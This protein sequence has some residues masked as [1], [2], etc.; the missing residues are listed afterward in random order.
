MKVKEENVP[1]LR[2]PEFSGEWEKKTLGEFFSF[3][4]GVNADKSKYGS[5]Y[6]FVN[7]LDIIADHP[8]TSDSIIGKVSISDIEFKKNEVLFGD[9]LF[10]RCS[11]TREEVG[12]SNVYLDQKQS[13]T[14]GGFVIRGRPITELNSEF[15]ALLLKTEAAK[16]DIT[17]R[18][19]GSTRYNIGQE[20][21]AAVLV[22]V[23][24]SLPEQQKVASFLS[25]VDT[26][27][28][29]LS[30]KK[31]LLEQYKK[32]FMQ[33]IFS[34]ELRF[35]DE[36]GNDFPDWEERRLKDIAEIIGGGTPGTG[37]SDY[38]G[39]NIQWFTPTEIKQKYLSSSKRTITEDGLKN[40]SA[41]KLPIGTLLLSTRATVGDV[42]IATRECSTNQ[43]FQSLLIKENNVNEYWFYW[44]K[45]NKTVLLRKSS[46]ST[47]LEISKSEI[48][49]LK[50]LR[51]H[52]SEQR[53]ISSFLSSL[54]K[55]INL[56][57]TE[58]T[59]AQTFK[60]GLLQQMFV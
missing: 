57:S 54:D 11:E 8:I 47:F 18:S 25:A 52:H 33:K 4:N 26:K 1:V 10:Q 24:S 46:G 58:L 28:N 17:S 16:K 13:A 51:P 20:S 31:A 49:K 40:S 37:N 34:Q 5:G 41:K 6:K 59:H 38:W 60:K 15:F 9:I 19:G 56:I 2:F 23:T 44:I 43:G 21:L 48:S 45:Q 32:G 14:F 7:V 35:K 12:Q 3:K 30:K 55:K 39:G 29:Q 22:H 42:A 36:Q 50:V 27:I 53:K